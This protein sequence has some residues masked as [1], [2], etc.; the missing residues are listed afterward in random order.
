[1]T[2]HICIVDR[3]IIVCEC[4]TRIVSLVPPSWTNAWLVDY[5]DLRYFVE[6]SGSSVEF[7]TLD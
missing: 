2:R 3:H 4:D 7:R 1:M 6:H 5:A